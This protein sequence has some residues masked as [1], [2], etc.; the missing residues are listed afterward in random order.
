M[1]DVQRLTQEQKQPMPD[2]AGIRHPASGP[3]FVFGVAV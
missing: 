2:D 1:L 3:F